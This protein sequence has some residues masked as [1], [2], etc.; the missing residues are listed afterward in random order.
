[1][2]RKISI[3]KHRAE[4]LKKMASISL[5]R[6]NSFNKMEYP[7]HTLDDYY[8]ILHQLMDAV[9]LLNGIKFSGNSAHKELIDWVSTSL[10]FSESCRNFLQKIR[11]YRNKIS[12]EGFFVKP[13]F[14]KQNDK[15]ILEIIK[16][17]DKKLEEKLNAIR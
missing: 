15:K 17:L 9:S 5:K 14:I 8:D 2:K 16:E 12:Y 7:S 1:M 11:N 4:S 10:E 3:D 6:L 13:N